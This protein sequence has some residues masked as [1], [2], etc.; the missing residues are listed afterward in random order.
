[1]LAKEYNP[2]KT[3]MLEPLRIPQMLETTANPAEAQT[4][5]SSSRRSRARSPEDTEQDIATRR[6]LVER[7]SVGLQQAQPACGRGALSICP[8]KR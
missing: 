5:N 4:E 2:S 1:M 6:E 7:R 3:I 8:T